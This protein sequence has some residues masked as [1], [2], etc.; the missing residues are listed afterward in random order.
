ML[1]Y[2]L[3]LINKKYEGSFWDFKVCHH[4][5]QA[6]LLHDILCMANNQTY[7]DGLIIFGVSND[8]EVIGVE[9]D[10]FR[11]TQQNIIDFLS[12]L[13]FVGELRPTIE[14]KTF[15][16]YEK[17]I[18][19]LII[20]NDVYT[21]Y[22]LKENYKKV[23]NN[24]VYTR[25]G[26]T[27]T[28]INKTADINHME[29]LWKKRFGIVP[30]PLKRFETYLINKESWSEKQYNCYYIEH[31]EFTIKV[32]DENN[33]EGIEFYSY[34]MMNKNTTFSVIELCYFSTVLIHRQIVW[35]DSGRYLTNCPN[36]GSIDCQ[37]YQR[38]S[39]IYKYFIEGTFDYNLHKFLFDENSDE[40]NIAHRRFMEVILVFKSEIE[41]DEF[42]YFITSNVALV[43]EE[44]HGAEEKNL[45]FE[46]KTETERKHE[47]HQIHTAIVLKKYLDIL[48]ESNY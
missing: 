37:M 13:K 26:D 33:S 39:L 41:R 38:K 4:K 1:E 16:V 47:N 22:I 11:R 40:A 45:V 7:N 44:I 48:R 2:I 6:D 21:P 34:M 10:Q 31:P 25:I 24:Y 36:W 5:E 32:D 29:F 12:T 23:S 17:R 18:D 3:D 19:V 20:R 9:N 27:N 46:A 30:N 43:I 14:L 42:E 35:L 8:G 28:P 15:I